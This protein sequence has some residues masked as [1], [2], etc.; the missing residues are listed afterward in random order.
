MVGGPGGDVCVA[1]PSW[2]GCP[3]S[4]L[5]GVKVLGRASIGGE[6][7]PVGY[8]WVRGCPKP[9][10]GPRSQGRLPESPLSPL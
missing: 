1:L 10:G 5:R 2:Q 9:G 4:P 3:C 6:M 8:I 7:G